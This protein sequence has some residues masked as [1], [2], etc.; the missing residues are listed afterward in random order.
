MGGE[1]EKDLWCHLEYV[2]GVCKGLVV[3]LLQS[4]S[5]ETQDICGAGA[6]FIPILA[7]VVLLVV[8]VVRGYC[9]GVSIRA[10]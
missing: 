4:R 3:M 2:I 10:N 7:A 5:L 6:L 1:N 8:D 9:F